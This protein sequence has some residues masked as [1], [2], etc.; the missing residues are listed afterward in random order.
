[1]T[2][3][4]TSSSAQTSG[5][6][7]GAPGTWPRVRADVL[8]LAWVVAAA[9]AVL[10]PALRHG[11]ALYDPGNALD[12]V[13][14]LIPWTTQ[15]WTQVHHGTLPLWNPYSALGMPLAFNWQSAP[16][17][18]PSLVGYLFPL[19]L[20]F[21]EQIVMTLLV[22]GSGV[23]ALAR[24]LGLGVLSCAFAATAYELSGPVMGWLG[25]PVA[26]VLSWA[27]WLFFAAVLI[28]RGRRR[29]RAIGLFSVVLA[30]AIYAGQP[31]S[32]VQLVLALLLFVAVVLGMQARRARQLRRVGRPLRDLAVAGVLGAA[33]GA[34]LA[35]PA[36]QLSL[37]SLQSIPTI[38]QQQRGPYSVDGLL[39]GFTNGTYG[40][41]AYLG[42]LC[43]AL[44][45][46]ALTLHRR[47]PAVLGMGAVAV[48]ATAVAFVTPLVSLLNAVP[49]IG[50]LHW[51]RAEV[52]MAFA[53]AVLAGMGVELLVASADRRAVGG[54]FLVIVCAVAV[55]AF[56]LAGVGGA[57]LAHADAVVRTKTLVG[58]AVEA[59]I[60]LAG[61]VALV[62]AGRSAG[63]HLVRSGRRLRPRALMGCAL[64]ACETGFLVA[65]GAGTMTAGTPAILSLTQNYRELRDG[66]GSSIV[67]FGDSRFC[68]PYSLGILQNI[69]IIFGVQ[70]LAVLDPMTPSGYVHSWY[71]TSGQLTGQDWIFCPAVTTAAAARRYGVSYVLDPPGAAGPSGAAFVGHVG[72]SQLFRVPGAASATLVPASSSPQWP[73]SDAAG[74]AVVLT[75][76][77]AASA[78][79]V[80]DSSTGGVLRLRL[81]DVPGWRATIDG[82]PLALH[83]F[84]KIMFQARVPKGRHV[85]ELR[86]WPTAFSAGL[87]IAGAGVVGVVLVFVTGWRRRPRSGAEVER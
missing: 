1:M 22:A 8:G 72:A 18:L 47:R 71:A 81:T 28:L 39:Y 3:T 51:A 82:R 53:T 80:T 42:L 7:T 65:A 52:L 68:F 35:L 34:P 74:R 67:A 23:Y 79:L 43:V 30:F 4:A 11:A 25:Q 63:S 48:A 31:E 19:R 44:A 17:S 16:L 85:I 46:L 40:N 55:A 77:D 37:R 32:L 78:R 21:T 2:V 10:V 66:V 73:P 57:Q 87:W 64:L 5:T 14:A 12:Q 59:G 69:N 86:Y 70:E 41:G 45:V 83:P 38:N 58:R 15:V 49:Y 84:L 27:G 29:A 6:A 36:V 56:V 50:D 9:F 13:D 62:L 76:P 61:A 54:R 60:G 33:L 26:S 24:V 75:R 20:A